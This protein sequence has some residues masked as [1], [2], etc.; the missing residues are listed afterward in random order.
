MPS[1]TGLHLNFGTERAN[2]GSVRSKC[3]YENIEDRISS[4]EGK[5]KANNEEIWRK[6][7]VFTK[8]FRA[9]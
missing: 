3:N 6:F 4:F 5:I 7:E 8:Q 1:E 2:E 9:S